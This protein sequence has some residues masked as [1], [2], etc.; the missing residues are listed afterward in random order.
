M[1]TRAELIQKWLLYSL[2]S[3][4][5]LAVQSLLLAKIRIF[6]L[7]PFLLPLIPAIVGSLEQ[8]AQALGFSV[9][10]GILCDAALL[11]A[12][13][14]F[15]LLSSVLVVLLAVFVSRRVLTKGML[16][17]FITSLAALL[18]TNTINA[19]AVFFAGG[20]ALHELLLRV[21]GTSLVSLFPVF[22]MHPLYAF[23]HRRLHMYD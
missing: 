1:E 21:A 20:A 15:Y 3:L 23:L 18:L 4:F 8:N 9:G 19:A 11:G 2:A 13:P 12:F 17:S 22:F 6:S 5:F 16:C 14:C 10:F 7:T